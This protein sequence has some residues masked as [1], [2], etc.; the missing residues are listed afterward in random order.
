M[1]YKMKQWF[2][3]WLPI[4]FGWH[5]RSDR[6]FF[7]KGKQ[8][9]ICARCTGELAGMICAIFGCYF[10]INI[11][12]CVW[13]ALL[14]PL[15]IDGVIQ[16]KTKYESTNTRRVITGFLFGMALM[17]IFIVSTKYCLV[18][19]FEYG[20]KLKEWGVLKFSRY[21]RKKK[22]IGNR[23]FLFCVMIVYYCIKAYHY[24]CS[25]RKKYNSTLKEANVYCLFLIFRIVFSCFIFFRSDN[26]L[27]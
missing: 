15:I 24:I 12:I 25:N 21:Y 6:S 16:A 14:C 11:H 4:I 7:Y 5:R 26:N 23:Q 19:G 9:P 22:G 10:L 17:M 2:Y 18:I 20:R 3:K 27:Y 13:V 1:A 8:F